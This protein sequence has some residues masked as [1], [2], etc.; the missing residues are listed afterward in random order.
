MEAVE[1]RLLGPVGIWH[2][3]R[4][5]GPT[6]S[7]VRTVLAMLLLDAGRVVPIDA[8]ITALWGEDPPPSARNAVQGYVSRLRRI[9]SAVPD[10]ELSTSVRGY[11]L[12]VD[13]SLVDLHRFRELVAQARTGDTVNAGGSLRAAL[14][15]WRGPAL[16]DTAGAWL[17]A[18]VGA[19][20]E[21][22]R[23]A[24]VDAGAAV[25]LALGRHDEVAAELSAVIAEHPLRERSVSL[26]VAALH[27]MGR[28]ADALELFHQ[29]R[30]RLVDNLGIEPGEELRRVH[31]EVLESRPAPLAPPVVAAVP[32]QLPAAS[33]AFTG[34]RAE[35]AALH[36][37]T[38]AGGQV[39]IVSGAA[40]V[41]KT[42]L[43]V[44]FGHEVRDLFPDG[45]LFLNL[46][47]FHP[48]LPMRPA[49]ALPLLLAALGVPPERMPVSLDAQVALYR[50]TIADRRVLLVLDNV[51]DPHQV[52]P[53]L[54]GGPGSLVLV[55]SRD[56]LGGLVAIE[57]AH[58]LTLDVLPPA[59]A[60]ALLTVAAGPARVGDDPRAAVA[61]TEL[62]GHLPLALRIAGAQLADRPDL[63]IGRHVAEL[64][65]RGRT[66]R[67]SVD[68]DSTA[69]VRGAFDL[70]YQALSPAARRAFRLLGLV[71]APAGLDAAAA[72]ALTGLSVPDVEPLID[73]L[74]RLH[75]VKVTTSGRVVY[76]DLLLQYA[77]ELAAERDPPAERDAATLRLLHFYLHTTDHAATALIGRS[78]LRLPRDPAPPGIA[79][80][81]FAGQAP[82]REWIAAEWTNLVAALDH[83]AA[84]ALPRIVWQL[85]DALRDFMQMQ[86]PP[87]Q[88]LHI[89]RTGLAAAGEAGFPLGAAG[90][91]LSLGFLRWRMA[92]YQAMLEESET[93]AD[94]ALRARWQEGRA[95]ALCNSGI[96][97][98]HL[99]RTQGATHK[100][101]LSLAIK[102]EIGDRA[103]E[104]T[105]L[106]NLTA[107]Y[108]QVGNLAMARECAELAV[109]LL[110]ELGRRQEEAI[111]QENLGMVRRQQGHLDNAR[112]SL[113]ESLAISRTIGALHE[114][115]SALN[116][117]GLVH[118]DAG[119]YDDAAAALTT[120]LDIT[121]RSSDSRLESL[122]RTSLA[123]VHI[124]QGRFT[125]AA[126][127][128]ERVFDITERTGHH[129]GKVEA[130]L[131]LAELCGAEGDHHRAH[132]HAT[133]AMDL[134]RPA[135]YALA[136]AQAHSRLAAASLGMDHL[137]ECVEHCRRALNTQRRAGQRLAYARTLLTVG[138]AYHRLG[139]PHLARAQWRRA[140]T[141]LTEIG[142]PEDEGAVSGSPDAQ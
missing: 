3:G 70:S 54:P 62:C 75:L 48:G 105:M 86:A 21:D 76:H 123:S 125:D 72:A 29:T 82:A 118:R 85:A 44:R 90:M 30:R 40:G 8:V 12:A 39:W 112:D 27:G 139:K 46:R 7:Q 45:Q 127:S 100:L 135:G 124:R 59:D 88:G 96:A 60:L 74:A 69:T 14:A 66:I 58:R 102:R 9:L 43:A 91:R 11:H 133:V 15:L 104:A 25:D 77:A 92:D 68:G 111:A 115:A 52:R 121:R 122:A 142:A 109:P 140:R 119:R 61:L 18:V 95:A 2:G 128:L 117:L 22:E 138:H 37:G 16:V 97:L 32:R 17:P 51:A 67:L 4:S 78:R 116:T 34:R 137:T 113:H 65:V 83:S 31:K 13:R 47:G 63:A 81:G 36:A 20:L 84:S 101:K 42:S 5:L 41:G 103:G 80:V 99:G 28:R 38:H 134:A 56:R 126:A 131:A 106:I 71:P 129:R 35:L 94:L 6:R 49:E 73:A 141:E 10:A 98:A 24:V 89:A 114:E 87:A 23:L 57:G 50:S 110:R 120:S 79:P 1:F 33:T 136:S 55:T 107:A 19:T 64:A 53:L 108:E 132:Q 93:A 130:L 26:L